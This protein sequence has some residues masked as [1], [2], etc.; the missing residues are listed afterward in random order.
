MNTLHYWGYDRILYI[1]VSL[2]LICLTM[3]SISNF[4]I[5]QMIVKTESSQLSIRFPY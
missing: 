4:H 1:G 2:S 3:F 5:D